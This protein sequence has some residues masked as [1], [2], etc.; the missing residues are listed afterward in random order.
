MQLSYRASIVVVPMRRGTPQ[1]AR[2]V[3]SPLPNKYLIGLDKGVTERPQ[4]KTI[5]GRNCGPIGAIEG[6]ALPARKPGIGHS[7][8]LSGAKMVNRQEKTAAGRPFA[9]G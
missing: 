3:P 8:A 6:S 2:P 4:R 7:A 5:A 9:R 1:R